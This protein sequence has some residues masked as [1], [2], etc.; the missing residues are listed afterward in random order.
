MSRDN[1]IIER[2]I[3][4]AASPQSI[5]AFLLDP[6]LMVHW[7]GLNHTLE[8]RPGG[9]FCV[10]VSLDH[11]ARGVFTE[12]V[13]YRKVGIH[14]GLGIE[15]SIAGGIETGRITRGDRTRATRG[16]HACPLAA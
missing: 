12:V 13:P 14:L 11:L 10:Q 6:M 2:E 3:L 5:F 8:P 1:V 9:M 16:W 7:F 15:R 4:I